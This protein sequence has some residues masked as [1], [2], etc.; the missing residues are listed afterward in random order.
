MLVYPG[1]SVDIAPTKDS[2]PAFLV[3]SANDRQDIG[4]GL[5]EAYLRFK[6]AGAS[7]ELILY[8]SGGHGFGVRSGGNQGSIGG[9]TD[10]FTEWL[11]GRGLLKAKR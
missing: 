4:E 5:A 11:D 8:A 2:P 9:W 3:A 7:V 1:R 6:K 10:R